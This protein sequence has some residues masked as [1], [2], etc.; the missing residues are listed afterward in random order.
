MS[1]IL[2]LMS[3]LLT[4]GCMSFIKPTSQMKCPGSII[5]ATEPWSSTVLTSAMLG[6]NALA[7]LSPGAY[8]QIRDAAAVSIANLSGAGD[9]HAGD[10]IGNLSLGGSITGVLLQIFNPA[11][12]LND[13]DRSIIVGYL[14]MI[15]GE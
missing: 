9:V 12:K 2:A 10:L 14:K 8:H 7:V 5:E 6:V 11:D 3:I 4:H 1:T 13:C 15:A